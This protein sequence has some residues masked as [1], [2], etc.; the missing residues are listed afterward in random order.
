MLE[1]HNESKNHF[2]KKLE[3]IKEICSW[4]L[5]G[6]DRRKVCSQEHISLIT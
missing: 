5:F 3:V 2:K 6:L 4:L 1:L